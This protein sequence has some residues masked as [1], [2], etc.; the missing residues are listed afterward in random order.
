MLPIPAACGTPM[1]DCSR[2]GLVARASSG[3]RVNAWRIARRC[4]GLRTNAGFAVGSAGGA[5]STSWITKVPSP[6]PVFTM[7]SVSDCVPPPGLTTAESGRGP[8]VSSAA[9]SRKSTR[10]TALAVTAAFFVR[11]LCRSAEA[12]KSCGPLPATKR[13]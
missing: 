3:P 11:E 12:S 1:S 4:S 10:T 2:P 6:V 9:G 7:S 13:E 5:T 8:A